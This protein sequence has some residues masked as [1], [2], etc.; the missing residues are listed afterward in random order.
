MTNPKPP[1]LPKPG[2]PA[3]E[4]LKMRGRSK[5]DAVQ[6]AQRVAQDDQG[7]IVEWHYADCVVTL[8]HRRGRYRVRQVRERES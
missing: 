2:M 6:P 3:D 1:K 7:M 5:A 4:V 8:H